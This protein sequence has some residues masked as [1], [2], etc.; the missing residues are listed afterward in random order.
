MNLSPSE[1]FTFNAFTN[2][3]RNRWVEFSWL[4]AVRG[5]GWTGGLYLIDDWLEVESAVLRSDID[6]KR[7]EA[8]EVEFIKEDGHFVFP[9]R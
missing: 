3:E 2:L 9:V 5:G 6:L 1:I 7:L 8:D 4:C